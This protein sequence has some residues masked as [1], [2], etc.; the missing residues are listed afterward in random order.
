TVVAWGQNGYGECN[1]PTGLSAV[2]A[3]AA[4]GDHTVALK[5]DG[6]VVVWGWNAYSACNVPTSLNGAKAIAAGYG[7]TV[8]LKEDGTVVAW[9]DNG[10]GQCNVPIAL[11]PT[12]AHVPTKPGMKFLGIPGCSNSYA[13]AI[14]G[15]GQVIGTSGFTNDSASHG[16]IW[17]DDKLIN[18]DT[19]G[20]FDSQVEAINE[21]G[22]VLGSSDIAGDSLRHGFIW[23]NGKVTDLGAL[24]TYLDVVA[25]NGNGRAIGG[26]THE[27]RDNK[28]RFPNRYRRPY[29]S[30]NKALHGF[31]WE[32]G[33]K[34]DLG[35]LGGDDS[36]VKAI[37]EKGQVIGES[38]LA[39]NY[40]QHGFIWENGKMTDLGT[41][42]GSQSGVRAINEKGQVI[43]W[44][45]VAGNTSQHE[46]VWEN[47]KMTDLSTPEGGEL[48]AVAINNNGQVVGWHQF[49]DNAGNTV[50]H[51]FIWQN[52]KITDLGTLGGDYSDANAINDN[53]QVI[54]RSYHWDKSMYG[55]IWENGKMTD[56]GSLGGNSSL[57]TN[58]EAINNK[59]QVV[60]SS[61][62]ADNTSAHGFM[63]EKGKMT[64]LGTLG[65]SHSDARLISENGNVIGCS[66]D[67]NQGGEYAFIWGNTPVITI[68]PY[69]TKPTNKDITVTANTDKGT[70]NQTSYTFTQNGS[71]T[72]TATD[73]SGNT[74][75]QTVTITNIDK[76]PP[77]ITLKGNPI[78]YVTCGGIYVDA[79]AQAI[80][81]RNG[82]ISSL[83][84][85]S[86]SV[87]TNIPSTYSVTYSVFDKAG[88]A[89]IPV[90]RTVIVMS[91]SNSVTP[92]EVTYDAR[93]LPV[94]TATLCTVN[95]LTDI[96]NGSVS[97]V[98]GKDYTVSGSTLS[99]AP[100]YFN[101]YFNK[102]QDQ[103][104]KLVLCFSTGEPVTLTVHPYWEQ[105]PVINPEAVKIDKTKITDVSVTM[106]LYGNTLTS[107]NNGTS[108]LSP[109][110]DYSISGNT[111]T[112]KKSYITYYFNKF[113]NQ[114]L[115]IIFKFSNGYNQVLSLYAGD[116]PNTEI[117]P[118]AVTYKVGSKTDVT[119]TAIMNGNFFSSINNGTSA[120]VPR[121]DYTYATD[122]NTLY[123]RSSYI[124][125]YFNKF[126]QDLVLTINFTG[127][128]PVTLT[129][130]P[131]WSNV[132]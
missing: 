21:R 123:I 76:T 40:T 73:E 30:G 97:L 132:R 44:S 91:L 118:A 94:F 90:S 87:Y 6:T 27:Y 124:A 131:D 78:E 130:K 117:T 108:A 93:K 39:D 31:I 25:I 42:G 63:W 60:G 34:T 5:E 129:I 81:D 113:P 110:Y 37:N 62:L 26:P 74:S 84:S 16:F 65:G 10:H 77:V 96:K 82:D 104:L 126:N 18:L 53:G 101:Y 56:L 13:K 24:G 88:N 22:Q 7:H 2:K 3:I 102:F 80:D 41:L 15:R 72:F 28:Y 114:N 57:T 79:G 125:Y 85:V 95:K 115:N 14:N 103:D 107:I 55:F 58:P 45:D 49:K 122:T 120:L 9:G 99:I 71:F 19:L 89:A 92:L 109:V 68:N 70:L 33:K 119:V 23:E 64:D 116:S 1:A 32:D 111:V 29:E 48:C 11:K 52:G 20:L 4:G 59:G 43:G 69:D 75:S 8:A 66:L 106:T 38:Y 47:G 35:T 121:V 98:A 51:G 128:K 105:I 12:P 83:I 17:D 100:G 36:F 46:F 86:G 61:Y 112:I 54:G 127:G 50:Q 67:E